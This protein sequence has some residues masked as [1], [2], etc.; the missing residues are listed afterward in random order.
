MSAADT[1]PWAVCKYGGT[2]VA[3]SATWAQIV[4]RVRVLLPTHRV[5]LVVSAVSKVT[6]LLLSCIAEAVS[7]SASGDARFA[8]FS[9]VVKIHEELA[10]SLGGT[11]ADVIPVSDLLADLRRLLEGI[12]LTGEASARLRARVAAHGEL[13]SSLVGAAF[14][15]RSLTGTKVTRVDARALLVS[16]E[17]GDEGSA[18]G[19]DVF[20]EADVVPSTQ[21]ER[22]D[23]SAA[24]ASVVIAQGFIASTPEGATCLLGRGGSDT[25]G[26]LFAA[27]CAASHLEIWTDVNGMFSVR[28]AAANDSDC[29]HA[30][31][32]THAP[33]R[34]PPSHALTTHAG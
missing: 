32:H 25:S 4:A 19:D 34:A 2:S 20:L 33:S 14:L 26:A 15:A 21:P 16:S 7:P 27:F 9:A 24:G 23:L 12:V 28:G 17:R 10:A 13:L 8:S 30:H 11:A 18:R 1:R 31:T 3:T 22:A 5:W 29:G 6:N